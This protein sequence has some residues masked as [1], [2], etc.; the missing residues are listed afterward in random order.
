[1]TLASKLRVR[2]LWPHRGTRTLSGSVGLSISI[3]A[4][5]IGA[6]LMLKSQAPPLAPQLDMIEIS[7]VSEA[8]LVSI[9]ASATSQSSTDD[10]ATAHQLPNSQDINIPD[11]SNINIPDW[12]RINVPTLSTVRPG[13]H[14]RTFNELAGIFD[15]LTFGNS[16]RENTPCRFISTSIVLPTFV[17]QQTDDARADRDARKDVQQIHR[18]ANRYLYGDASVILV[19]LTRLPF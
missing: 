12:S 2:D 6:L 9:N 8:P 16:L 14:A 5:A 15:C 4:V 13:A 11:W 10:S 19:P 18:D 1:M 7:I 17:T 3:H